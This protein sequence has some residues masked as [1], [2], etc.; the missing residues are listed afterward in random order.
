M[1][2]PPLTVQ[3]T[4][5]YPRVNDF[6]LHLVWV[7]QFCV[8]I[9][10]AWQRIQSVTTRRPSLRATAFFIYRLPHLLC[11]LALVA[12]HVVIIG[13]DNVATAQDAPFKWVKTYYL[14]T[15]A[16]MVA[17]WTLCAAVVLVEQRRSRHSGRSL[18]VWWLL[19]FLLAVLRLSADIIW[20]LH[21]ATGGD[22]SLKGRSP[23]S[24]TIV[25]TAAFVPQAILGLLALFAADTPD[26]DV[27]VFV[28]TYTAAPTPQPVSSTQ[29]PL[30]LNSSVVEEGRANRASRVSVESESGYPK[31]P[32]PK[33]SS[34]MTASFA[35]KLTFSYLTETLVTGRQRGESAG[36]GLGLG[37]S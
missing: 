10:L 34:E 35:S 17:M 1:G 12:V 5:L 7:I 11:C 22:I 19:N 24:W 20:L 6:Y 36:L 27:D 23:S 21:P 8:L 28:D 4:E 31:L 2:L 32:Q 14:I 29:E 33:A 18:R 26:A 16:C 9:P 30:L 13:S 37:L 15:T 25:R 3:D